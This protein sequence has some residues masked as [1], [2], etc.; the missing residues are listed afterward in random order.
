MIIESNGQEVNMLGLLAIAVAAVAALIGY[1]QARAF[2][3]R[4]LA[5]VDVIHASYF[6]LAAGLT[7]AVVALPVVALLPLVGGGTAAL[8]G[9]AVGLGASAGVVDVR[10][11]LRPG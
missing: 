3:V 11:R 2:V 8:F 10:K 4:R 7:A 6:P 1:R 9:V 5:Y